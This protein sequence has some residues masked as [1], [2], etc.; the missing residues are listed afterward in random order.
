LLIVAI[1][2]YW[3]YTGGSLPGFANTPTPE[4]TLTPTTAP[5]PTSGAVSITSYTVDQEAIAVGGCI[6]LSWEVVNA[7]QIQLFRGGD[8]VLFQSE[9]SDT[10]QDCP[11]APGNFVYRLEASGESDGLESEQI[12]V[13]VA[14]PPTDTPIPTLAVTPGASTA[15]TQSQD[16]G[17]IRFVSYALYPDRI[18]LGECVELSWQ[19]ENAAQVRLQRSGEVVLENAP[20]TGSA[21]DCPELEGRSVYRLEASNPDG[22]NNFMELQVL[23]EEGGAAPTAGSGGGSTGPVTIM[24]FTVDDGQINRG[25]CVTLSWDVRNADQVTLLRGGE[26]LVENAQHASSFQECLSTQGQ[27]VYRLE[28]RNSGG[29]FNFLELHVTVL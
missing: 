4:I 15:P 27:A 26:V 5:T 3:A 10:F 2:F 8:M 22:T 9:A 12:R 25:Q 14:P 1:L 21:R 18:V 11:E 17:P 23:V 6:I 28:V 19:V 24:F 20:L 7:E 13:S 29:Y 16:P